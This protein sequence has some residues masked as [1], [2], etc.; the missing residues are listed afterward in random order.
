[1]KKNKGAA[2][3]EST[4]QHLCYVLMILLF[5]PKVNTFFVENPFLVKN[6]IIHNLFIFY[7][8]IIYKSLSRI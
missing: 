8:D 5:S 7:F 4:P 6:H 2:E 3:I 1:M